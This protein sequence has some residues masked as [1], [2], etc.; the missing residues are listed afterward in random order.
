Q[1]ITRSFRQIGIDASF[2]MLDFNTWQEKAQKGELAATIGWSE[3]GPTPYDMYRALMSTETLLPV[4]V[5]SENW[6][7][8]GLPA[9][10][11][12]L[13]KMEQTTDPAIE[14]QLVDGLQ[15]LFVE[16]APAIP[17]FPGP[18]FGEFTN[19]RFVGFPDREHPYAPLSPNW[20]PQSLLVLME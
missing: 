20:A 8:F 16:H 18:L 11:E 3:Y 5:L 19:E 6:H 17:L 10:D 7:R 1:V 15:L 14:K 9:A 2:Q 12:L 13:H 4:G